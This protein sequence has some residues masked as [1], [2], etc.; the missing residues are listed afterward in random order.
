MKRIFT[1]VLETLSAIREARVRQRLVDELDER[2][3]RDIGLDHEAN[4]ARERS[5]IALR[6]GAY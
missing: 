3:L 2:T 4:R 6:F 5:R 1:S